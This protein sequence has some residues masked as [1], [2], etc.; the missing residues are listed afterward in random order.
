LCHPARSLDDVSVGQNG[1]KLRRIDMASTIWGDLFDVAF[2]QR[3]VNANGVR[4]RVIE[5][6]QRGQPVLILLPGQTGHAEAYMRNI[7]PLGE[8]FHTLAI[9]PIGCGFS[10][11]PECPYLIAD[12]VE[13]L[14][15]FMDTEGIERAHISGESIGGWVALRFATTYPDRADKLIL[16]TCG[17]YNWDENV[18]LRI[19]N[20]TI[21]AV[22]NNKRDEVRARLEF[23][24]DDKSKVTEELVDIRQHI[25]AM[26]EFRKNVERMLDVQVPEIRINIRIT[27]E[28]LQN[29][30]HE[31]LVLWT[32]HDPTAPTSVADRMAELLPNS[33]KV[34][35]EGAGHWP[36]WEIP[37]AFNQVHIDFING[38]L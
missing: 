2:C 11:K 8:H 38:T 17:G 6:G 32:V 25:Y 22:M 5:T 15:D 13:H 34:I 4:T 7:G 23:L 3:W 26:P 28:E 1:R 16:N 37:A 9:D 12:Y 20:L 35:L 24:M 14:K 29:T 18:F 33:K 30:P 10:D 36:Q 21:P 27:D 19:R 31:S